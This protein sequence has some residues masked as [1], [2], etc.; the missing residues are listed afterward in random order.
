[1]SKYCCSDFLAAATEDDPAIFLNDQGEWTVW[2]YCLEDIKHC[3]FCGE[4]LLARSPE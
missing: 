3:P 1:M 2:G 4:K